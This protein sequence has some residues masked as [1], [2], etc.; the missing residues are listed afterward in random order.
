[1][2][3]RR[4]KIDEYK[5]GS[6]SP[7]VKFIEEL[8]LK[9]VE[10]IKS[11][12][13]SSNIEKMRAAACILNTDITTTNIK[14]DIEKVNGIRIVKYSKNLENIDKLIIYFHGGAYFGGS[15]D[16][17]HNSCKYIAE[18]TG[19]TVVSVDYS[20]A[21]EFPYPTAINEGY[22]ILKYFDNKYKN[23]YLSGD[24]AG[25]GLACSVCIK[26]IEE[27]T[28][29]TDGLILYYPFLLIDLEDNCRDDFIWDM[30]EYDIDNT[31]I[32]APLIKSL[33]T[34]LRD[35]ILFVKDTY[36]KTNE[37]K[38]NYYISQINAPDSLL[39]Q[40]PRTLMFTSEYDYLR[41]EAEY[42]HKRLKENGVNSIGI[43]YAGEVHAFIDK[44]G[45]SDNAIDSVNEIKEFIK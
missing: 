25:G 42:F 44:I 30:K 23:I 1:M 36:I 33:I 35:I 27:K 18:Q 34:E 12:E 20:L 7:Q 31:N 41:L 3:I 13:F 22:A 26:D 45:Y 16:I 15:T 10:K 40:F 43:R 2:D 5:I 9:E 6:L 39:K 24:S 11:R 17:V 21:P 37:T 19:T 14:I 4:P 28:K 8:R 32:D 38:G 29:I